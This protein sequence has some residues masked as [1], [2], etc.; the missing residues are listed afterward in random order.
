VEQSSE[1]E[2]GE[3][4]TRALEGAKGRLTKSS[5][6]NGHVVGGL[7]RNPSKMGAVGRAARSSSERTGEGG[8]SEEERVRP[9]RC[10]CGNDVAQPPTVEKV[11]TRGARLLTERSQRISSE[12]ELQKAKRDEKK[13]QRR[14]RLTS[15]DLHTRDLTHQDVGSVFEWVTEPVAS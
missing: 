2:V 4:G 10:I 6:M 8:R 11:G 1:R 12:E 7:D 13:S 15:T 5:S 14:E 3:E 9:I